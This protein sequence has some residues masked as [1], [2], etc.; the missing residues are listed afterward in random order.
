MLITFIKILFD[1]NL[2]IRHLM[3]LSILLLIIIII[4]ISFISRNLLITS[5]HLVIER[6]KKSI[7][8]LILLNGI[9][10]ILIDSLHQ[11]SKILH[12]ESCSWLL[13]QSI[14]LLIINHILSLLIYYSECL[15]CVPSIIIHQLHLL[16]LWLSVK[17]YF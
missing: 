9:I 2:L 16:N 7:T 15:H 11:C 17:L 6:R 12:I 10:Q 5:N 8:E 13:K 3:L 14:Q 1:H 4:L